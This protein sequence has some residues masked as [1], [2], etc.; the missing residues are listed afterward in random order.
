MFAQPVQ[1]PAS[2]ASALVLD[3]P[4]N[5]VWF[6]T[7]DG[8]LRSWR[9]LGGRHGTLGAGWSDVVAPVPGADGLTLFVV[10]A[11]GEVH[12]ALRSAA[13]RADAELWVAHPAGL[14][15]AVPLDDGGVLLLDAD[16][17][18]LVLRNRGIEELVPATGATALCVLEDRGELVLALPRGDATTL[19]RRSLA[20]GT[21]VDTS[22]VPHPVVSLTPLGD[23]VA[24]VDDAGSVTSVSWSSGEGADAF[25]LPTPVAHGMCSWHSLVFAAAG[26]EL[27][28]VEWGTDVETMPIEA[29]LQ[30]LAPGGWLPITVDYDA[31]GLTADR[32]EW[33]WEDNPQDEC[34]SVAGAGFDSSDRWEHRVLGGPLPGERTLVA[35]EKATGQ[36]LATRRFRV[37]GG[38]PDTEVG[39][40]QVVSGARQLYAKGGWGGGPAAPQNIRT[41]PAPEEY[42]IAVAVF[43]C[44]SSASAISEP[45]PAADR[46]DELTQHVVGTVG[47]SVDRWFREVSYADTP[48]GAGPAPKGTRIRLLKDAVIGPIDVPY[49]FG[50]LFTPGD[51]A[52]EYGSWDPRPDTWDR[53]GG[54]FSTF[55]LDDPVELPGGA[56][57]PVMQM[58]DAVVFTILPGSDEPVD[59][60]GTT[61]GALWTW[62]FASDAQVYWKPSD[63]ST[64]FTRKP[65]TCMP[66]AISAGHPSPWAEKEYVTTMVHELGHT[67]GMPD[68]YEKPGFPAEIGG[69]YV[70]SWEMMATDVT[71]PHLSLP[72]RMRLGWIDPSWVEVCDFSKNPA[73]RE[74]TL[75]ALE[76]LSRSGPGAGRKAGIE[77]RLRDGWNYYFE[78]RRDQPGQIGDQ[79]LPA[80]AVLGTDVFQAKADDMARPLILLLPNDVDGDGPVLEVATSD[81]EES[82]VTNPDRMNDF[83]LTRILPPLGATPDDVRVRVEYLGAHRAEL[84]LRPARGNGEWKSPDIGVTGP[85]GTDV[86]VKGQ[87]HR[88][89]MTV[90]NAGTKAADRVTLRVGWLPFTTTPGAWT[91]LPPPPAQ[92]I[93][94]KSSAVFEVE[95]TV[96]QS[97]TVPDATG[98]PIEAE[99]FCVRVDVDRYVDPLDPTGDEIVVHNN[100]AQSNFGTAVTGQS[101]P[102]SREGTAVVAANPFPT[103]A[104]QRHVVE[105]TGEEFRL[106]LDEGW[107]VVDAGATTATRL[108]FESFAGDPRRGRDYAERFEQSGGEG[109]ASDVSVRTFLLPEGR[110]DAGVP[111]FGAG[112]WLRAGWR[113]RFAEVGANGEVVFGAL[114]YEKDGYIEPVTFG[115]VRVVAHPEE[116][117]DE[118][119]WL[120]GGV[121][122]EG[123]FFVPVTREVFEGARAERWVFEVFF[124]S[125][126]Q[127]APSRSGVRPLEL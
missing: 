92:P 30:P 43:R 67:L 35:T 96:P 60:A 113:T 37:L 50:E 84:Q 40:P 27:T 7:T 41:H 118:V 122:Q 99:H 53:L 11:D 47:D 87:K 31:V 106:F 39:P 9:L 124:F 57:R 29:S 75:Q 117:P 107:R 20:D 78:H 121:D 95:W 90:R 126:Y 127:Y 103:R 58:A 62:A 86:V 109:I 55:V 3:P 38:W 32:V 114:V 25:P 112:L 13:D 72:H 52:D 98:T 4:G 12:R 94:A 80:D 61:V 49:A 88:I 33:Y 23:G 46:R 56:P 28:V 5:A 17:A 76:T 116:R 1:L 101:S 22:S 21:V 15:A 34:V 110:H 82:D 8:Q 93:G 97:V 91:A 89:R 79:M 108:A 105:Q 73:T 70:G 125:T 102:S 68:L 54:T 77:I 83:R 120:D 59:V 63:G 2:V 66:A 69:R 26:A 18:V 36:V 85:S 24:V 51:A 44:K 71:M 100:W 104:L 123:R 6:A 48:N 19:E 119:A 42:R 14:V 64:T 65:A 45:G 115:E 10:L 16:G 81:Y 111:G 74:V